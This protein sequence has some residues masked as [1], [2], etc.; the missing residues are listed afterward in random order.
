MGSTCTLYCHGM[1]HH[2]AQTW[3]VQ[4][5]PIACL[6]LLFPR[7]VFSFSESISLSHCAVH[8]Y[9]LLFPL[10]CAVPFTALAAV[11]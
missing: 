10:C 8:F 11:V 4:P 5:A 3:A 6:A 7:M 9:A 2:W 1:T